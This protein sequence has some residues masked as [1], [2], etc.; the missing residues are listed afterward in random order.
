[1]KR[2]RTAPVISISVSRCSLFDEDS[3]TNGIPF[4][5]VSV[6]NTYAQQGT[7]TLDDPADVI[8]LRDALT[9]FINQN[10][11]DFANELQD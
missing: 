7:I 9:A 1:M 11:H 2:A 10:P 6:S 8:Q 5:S 3:L 4:W